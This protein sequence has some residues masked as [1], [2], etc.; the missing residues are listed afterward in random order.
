MGSTMDTVYTYQQVKDAWQSYNT[1]MCWVG[2]NKDG[3]TKVYMRAPD[4]ASG[5][6]RSAKMVKIR[7]KISFPK[8]LEMTIG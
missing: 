6:M 7:D 8:Y 4:L 3:A 5:S 2:L 1:E